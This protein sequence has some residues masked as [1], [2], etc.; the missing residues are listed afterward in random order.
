MDFLV[1][2]LCNLSDCLVGGSGCTD[3]HRTPILRVPSLGKVNVYLRI[4]ALFTDT[5]T[6]IA[7]GRKLIY[8]EPVEF[9]TLNPPSGMSCGDYMQGYMSFAGG[10]LV[11]ASASA[12]C[13]FCST[14]TTDEFLAGN[15]NIRY[16]DRWWHLG[17]FVAYIVFNVRRRAPC[18][19]S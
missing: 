10:Y 18:S 5:A 2:A 3:S 4:S 16:S 14:R 9:V 15:F 6:I 17:I 8:C 19:M 12:A 13:Q 11:D 1:T 7:V